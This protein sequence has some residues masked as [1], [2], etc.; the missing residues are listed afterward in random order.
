MI[1]GVEVS[2]AICTK[3]PST[4]LEVSLW[5]GINVKCRFW[6]PKVGEF[7]ISLLCHCIAEDFTWVFIG[8]YGP[9]EAQARDAFWRELHEV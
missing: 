2:G 9:H 8:V 6:I 7:S 1:C 3:R 4:L 5:H